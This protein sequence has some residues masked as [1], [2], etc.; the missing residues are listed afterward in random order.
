MY[1]RKLS[2]KLEQTLLEKLSF[3]LVCILCQDLMS[4]FTGNFPGAKITTFSPPLMKFSKCVLEQ[5]SYKKM[6]VS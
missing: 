6:S 5:K 2:F 1:L 4:S 3:K